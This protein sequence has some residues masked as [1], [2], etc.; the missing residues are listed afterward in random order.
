MYSTHIASHAYELSRTDCSASHKTASAALL[1]GR[2]GVRRLRIAS[3]ILLQLGGVR[4][5]AMWYLKM[6]I[7]P[8]SEPNAVQI[9]VFAHIQTVLELLPTAIY[10]F[11]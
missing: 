2:T 3:F 1:D 11:T 7:C 9:T 8:P 4:N 10:S 5:V 6:Y